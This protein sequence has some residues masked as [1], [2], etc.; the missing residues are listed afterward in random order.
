MKQ[1]LVRS[2]K[3]FLQDVPA[4]VAG[5]KNVLVRV[6]R[7]CVSVGTEMAG[8]KMSGLPLYRRALK[9]PHHVKRVLQLMRDQGV[10][11]VYKQVKGKLDAGL[12]TGYSAAGTVIA[13]GSE[14]DGIAIGDRI[15]C[16]GA[17]VANH[18]EV[19]DV[20]VNLCVPIP[21]QVSFDAAA[22]VT[23]GAIAMQGVRRAQ[24]TLGETVVVIGLGILGQITAQ[25]L[26]ANGC[27]VIGTDVDNKRISTALENGL[28]HGINPNDGNLVESIIKLTDGVGADAAIITAASASSDILAQAFQSCR[29]KARVVIVG[30]VGLNMARSD[31]YAKELDVLISCSYGPGRYDPVYEEEGADYPLAYVR[32]TENRNMGEYLRLLAAGRL[33]L[34]NMLHEPYPVDRAEEAYGRLAGEGEKPLLVLLQYPHREEAVRSVLQIAAP[35][36]VDGRIKIAVVGAGSFAQGM[37]LPN[38]KKLGDKFDLRSVV[39]RTGLSARTAAERFGFSTASTDFQTVL[40]DPQVDLVLIA[41]R[42]DLHAE[43]T[44][45]ALKAGKHVFVEKPLSMTEEGLDAIEAFYEANPNGPLLMTGFN[46]R[47]APAVSAAREVI[48]RRLSPMI[49]N[50]RMNAGY[51]P[52]DHW[53]HGPHGGGR[54]IGEACHIY[55]LFNS[56]TGSQPVEVQARSIVPASG[57]W[58]RDDNFV[59]TVR[60]ADGS[61]CTLTY[62]SLGSKE[63]PKER[64]DIFVDGK[65]LV[66]DDYK[67]LEVTGAKAGWKGLTIEKG[68]FEELVAL[69][70]AFKP[71]GKW[72][73]SLADQLSATRVSFAVEKQLAE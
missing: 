64:F 62:T 50:Y 5:P 36:P 72:P 61:L 59:A 38:L 13:I 8:V 63:F 20:P 46:R 47:F 9:Q 15:A 56:L 3:V 16:A 30:D 14:V 49:V 70:E 4:P 33:R 48:K 39:S 65:V 45:A 19:I 42:H 68:Q 54:N 17:G 25:L 32:W 60:Y 2:G 67:R 7:S 23:L 21:Q 66:L 34:D 69:A 10:A 6:E 31:I 41:T 11:R 26:T 43:M 29:K 57:H 52:S 22:T 24:P 71:G 28:D 51:I 35:K 44:V 53:V 1:L 18:A 58:R 12:P 27:R 37:H 55:D 40:D 73:I